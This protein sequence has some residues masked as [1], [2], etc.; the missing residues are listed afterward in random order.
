MPEGMDFITS[1]DELRALY[2][3]PHPD[4]IRK[5]LKKLDAHAR[6]FLSRSLFVLIGTQDKGGNGDVSPKGDRPGLKVQPKRKGNHDV[7]YQP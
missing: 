1:Q 5:E 3:K 2:R 4:V 7:S 6:K